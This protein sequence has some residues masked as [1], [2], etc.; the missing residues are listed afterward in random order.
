MILVLREKTPRRYRAIFFCPVDI[1][2]PT[3]ADRER[4]W[5]PT[6][7]DEVEFSLCK[8][9]AT[10]KV[11]A[12][13]ITLTNS[14]SKVQRG[15]VDGA[16]RSRYGF[17]RPLIAGEGSKGLF[18]IE[19]GEVDECFKPGG[20][21]RDG[22]VRF[23][24]SE[25]HGGIRL[26]DG[27]EVEYTLV[28]NRRTKEAKAVRIKLI[29]RPVIESTGSTERKVVNK[30]LLGKLAGGMAGVARFHQ[31]QKPDGTNGFPVGRGRNLPIKTALNPAAEEWTPTF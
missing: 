24:A 26:F 15:I 23:E 31:A 16:L 22:T 14:G 27:D 3:D 11:R 5:Y 29:N 6:I 28:I 19:D 12:T 17:V 2:Q 20:G 9:V 13:K 10:K 18:S 21:G 25:I 1:E 7:G 4:E 8:N 30:E